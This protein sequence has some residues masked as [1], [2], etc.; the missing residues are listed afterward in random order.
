M[1]DLVIVLIAIIAAT[2]GW[3]HGAVAS[4]MAFVGVLAGAYAGI[5][6]A[7][8]VL[9]YFDEGRGRLF[10]GIFLIVALVILGELVG[11]LIGGYARNVIRTPIARAVDSTIGAALQAAAVLFAAWLLAIPLTGSSQPE[12]AAAV[13]GSE[14]LEKVDSIA[15]QWVKNLP[16]EF[17]AL[18]DTSGL[19]DIIGPFGKTPIATVEPPN[20][21]VLANPIVAGLQD[22]VLR[23]RGT[24]QSCQRSLEGSGFVIA[25]ERVMTNAHV[26]AGTDYIAVDVD[27]YSLDATVVLFDPNTD[28][29]I[30]D[31]PGLTKEPV[32]VASSPADSGQDAIVLGYPGGGPYTASAARIRE[33]LELTGP[34]IYRGDNVEREVYTVRGQIRQGNSGGPL[35]DTSGRLLGVV[36]GAAVDNTDTGFV[37]TLKEVM[38]EYSAAP[39]LTNVVSTGDCVN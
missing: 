17:E 9:T 23:I 12:I 13:R 19:P 32:P 14:V 27:G 37:L 4:F 22:Q 30:L 33:T 38:D 20:A 1:L 31:V 24:A 15:P 29:A 3:R 35:I 6:I 16:K 2:S 34:D 7:P 36:F 10:I 26:V 21:D 25:P 28:I 18:L 8:H 39:G 5:E 11:M